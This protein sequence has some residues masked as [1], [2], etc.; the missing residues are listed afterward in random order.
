MS[1]SERKAE[2]KQ[3]VKQIIGACKKAG[4]VTLDKVIQ[5][6][7]QPEPY[8]LPSKKTVDEVRK[9]ENHTVIG[10]IAGA[11]LD[12]GAARGWCPKTAGR[13]GSAVS[14]DRAVVSQVLQCCIISVTGYLQHAQQ[15]TLLL[16]SYSITGKLFSCYMQCM[17]RPCFGMQSKIGCHSVRFPENVRG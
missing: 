6:T 14:V 7:R 2:A 10:I 8:R 1:D 9:K 16:Y 3:R 13:Q 5:N 4:R 12:L 17:L 15:L 11:S